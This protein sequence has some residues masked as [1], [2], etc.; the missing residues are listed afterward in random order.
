MLQESLLFLEQETLLLLNLG[1]LALLFFQLASSCLLLRVQFLAA[2]LL[3]LFQ[4]GHLGVFYRCGTILSIRSR[5]LNRLLLLFLFLLFLALCRLLWRITH[6]LQRNIQ[7]LGFDVFGGH[8]IHVLVEHLLGRARTGV[9]LV[10]RR[11][12]GVRGERWHFCG[13]HA[14]VS[15]HHLGDIV[16]ELRVITG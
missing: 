16:D 7:V 6:I 8:R 11:S 2:H 4:V 14:R 1:K 10:R 3:N 5:L 9:L 15:L 12:D 13:G